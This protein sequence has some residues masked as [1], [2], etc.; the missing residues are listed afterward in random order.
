M[1]KLILV[2]GLS[3]LLSACGTKVT[4]TP[5]PEITQ[6]NL[7]TLCDGDT[8]IPVNYVLDENGERVYRGDE[9]MR[10]LVEWQAYYNKCAIVHNSLVKTLR[11][12]QKEKKLTIK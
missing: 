8:P 4:V 10:V 6:E 1:K 11:D 9:I 3:I 2:L 7:L 5:T 12:L